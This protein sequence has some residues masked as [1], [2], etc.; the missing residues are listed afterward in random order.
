N[1]LSAVFYILAAL[2]YLRFDRE[3]TARWHAAALL[4]FTFALLSKSV[5]A[6]L[7]AALLVLVWWRRAR[8]SAKRDL[9]PLL[10]FLAL[11]AIMGFV[12]AHLERVHVGAS[13]SSFELGPAG[14]LLV[15]G[16]ALWF[17]LAK[18]V[19]PADLTFI[20]PRWTLDASSP[21]QWFFPVSA[22]VVLACFWFVRGRTRAPLAAGLLFAGTLFP[23]LGFVNLFPFLY[24]FVADHFQYLAMAMVA[25]AAAAAASSA[26]R[27]A[28]ISRLVCFGVTLLLGLLTWRQCRAYESSESLWRATIERNPVCWMAFNNLAVDDLKADRV[29]AAIAHVTEGLRLKPDNAAAHATLGEAMGR[30]GRP[31]PALREYERALELE[32]YNA[33]AHTNLADT[34]LGLG[35]I[36]ES[37]AHFRSA[38]EVNPESA[39]AMS[40]LGEAYLRRGDTDL[41]IEE[42]GRSLGADPADASVHANLGTAL[43]IKGRT[44]EATVQYEVG[45]GLDPALLVAQYNLGNALIQSGNFSSA[46]VHLSKALA[47]SPDFQPAHASLGYALL[48]EGKSEQA[49]SHL[50]R[51]LELDPADPRAKGYLSEALGH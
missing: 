36:D 2:A 43:M 40:G 37:M 26:G 22:L 27:M 21:A 17:Y 41:A 49:L 11:G 51:A 16:R 45:V 42:L 33:A 6:T 15:A 39:K 34:L 19:W 7:P 13:G 48:K 10:P 5:T 50:R 25:A 38:L 28:G 30:Q 31:L 23:A 3:R 1:T 35:R 24:S 14:R 44:Q 20:Y 12:T 8:I 18:I 29:D 47:I 9:A 4:L 46:A 32:P